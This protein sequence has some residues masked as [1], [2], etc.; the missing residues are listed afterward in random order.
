MQQNGGLQA[1]L[2]SLAMLEAQRLLRLSPDMQTMALQNLRLQSPEFA[3][4][5]KQMLATLQQQNG[6]ANQQGPQVDMRPLP[7]QR[8]PRRTT[9]LV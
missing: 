5:V 2:P 3:D 7:E 8:S 6:A 1:D 9:A 4:L